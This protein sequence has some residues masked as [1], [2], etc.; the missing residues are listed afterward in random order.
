MLDISRRDGCHGHSPR[1]STVIHTFKEGQALMIANVS[2]LNRKRKLC[3]G[4]AYEIVVFAMAKVVQYHY[5]L[6]PRFHNPPRQQM[7]GKVELLIR[8]LLVKFI[9]C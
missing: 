3:E 5:L 9:N 1:Q 6:M 4:F 2:T 8:V 7:I